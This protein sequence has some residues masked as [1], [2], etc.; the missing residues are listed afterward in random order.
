MWDWLGEDE[1]YQY[2]GKSILSRPFK[3]I[4][5]HVKPVLVLSLL[6]IETNA[7]DFF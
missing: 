4:N 1:V 3:Q 6:L 7:L 5:I 2:G